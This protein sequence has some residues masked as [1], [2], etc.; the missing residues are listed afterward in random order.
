LTAP[1]P[2]PVVA[3]S[4]SATG[5]RSTHKEGKNFICLTRKSSLGAYLRRC[6]DLV[7]VDGYSTP[8][9]VSNTS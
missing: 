8:Q 7:A 2:F 3:A 9:T 1:R 6:K 5:P 4:A